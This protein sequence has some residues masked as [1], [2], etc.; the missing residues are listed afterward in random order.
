MIF[1][2]FF[3]R[4][5]KRWEYAKE[6]TYFNNVLKLMDKDEDGTIKGDMRDAYMSY[7]ILTGDTRAL[8]DALELRRPGRNRNPDD[9]ASVYINS[10]IFRE[11]L[12]RT[13]FQDPR[14]VHE[15]LKEKYLVFEQLTI[16]LLKRQD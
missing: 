13:V 14:R 11:M 16:D 6:Q 9:G 1:K 3:K 7:W 12:A 10:A 8:I 4:I 5:K 15:I 2:K